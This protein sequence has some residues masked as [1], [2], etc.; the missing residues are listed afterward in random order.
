MGVFFV[1]AGLIRQIGICLNLL[2]T[3]LCNDT[4]LNVEFLLPTANLQMSGHNFH[5]CKLAE[6]ADKIGIPKIQ[7]IIFQR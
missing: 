5:I 1:I 7:N 3:I 6:Q 2:K 4:K